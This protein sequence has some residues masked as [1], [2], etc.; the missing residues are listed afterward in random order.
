MHIHIHIARVHPHYSLCC[1]FS[2]PKFADILVQRTHTYTHS[3]QLSWF[4]AHTLTH[5]THIQFFTHPCMHRLFNTQPTQISS[6]LGASSSREESRLGATMEPQRSR[7]QR[8]ADRSG[9]PDSGMYMCVP[10][11]VCVCA[12][13]YVSVRKSNSVRAYNERCGCEQ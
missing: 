2:S 11:S 9:H 5:G 13:A 6:H 1:T 8:T 4:K 7:G 12:H 10:V 3:M